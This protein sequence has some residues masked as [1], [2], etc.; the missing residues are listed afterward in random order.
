[1][2]QAKQQ[3]KQE[4]SKTLTRNNKIKNTMVQEIKSSNNNNIELAWGSSIFKNK[5]H[6]T[7]DL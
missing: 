6:T 3:Q 1:M 5:H 4:T 7:N 2:V